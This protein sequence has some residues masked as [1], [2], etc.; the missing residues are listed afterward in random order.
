[1]AMPM[2]APMKIPGHKR[3]K[4]RPTARPRKTPTGVVMA[5]IVVCAYL[6]VPAPAGNE[7]SRFVTN[8]RAGRF[9][10]STALSDWLGQQ[11]HRSNDFIVILNGVTET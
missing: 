4:R 8:S 9:C 2:A 1:M 7:S 3:S 11:H 5:P 6:P 10:F